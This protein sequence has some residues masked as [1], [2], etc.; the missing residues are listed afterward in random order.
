M[1]GRKVSHAE[2]SRDLSKVI[3][4]GS[5]VRGSRCDGEAQL[6]RS[7]SR[8]QRVFCGSSFCREKHFLPDKGRVP[9]GNDFWY[10]T[11]S[12]GNL[13]LDSCRTRVV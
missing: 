4:C 12:I 9:Q 2:R 13:R 7:L 5:L 3:R 1:N 6:M 11:S 8:V 10:E